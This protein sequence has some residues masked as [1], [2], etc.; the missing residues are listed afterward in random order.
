MSNTKHFVKEHQATKQNKG[1][2]DCRCNGCLLVVVW[3]DKSSLYTITNMHEPVV[4]VQ[5]TVKRRRVLEPV[6]MSIAP[7]F[8]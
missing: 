7:L 3:V 1:W 5:P 8:A 4:S 2:Y 6:R